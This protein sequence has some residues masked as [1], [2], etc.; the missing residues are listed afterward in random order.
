MNV[1]GSV[2]MTCGSSR[3]SLPCVVR[4]QHVVVRRLSSCA[5]PLSLM[6]VLSRVSSLTEVEVPLV[7][8]LV[9]YRV[10][11]RV[12]V[13]VLDQGQLRPACRT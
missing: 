10:G 11:V 7:G 1:H 8:V 6:I 12:P 4:R 5:G 13:L 2:P 9:T 3:P